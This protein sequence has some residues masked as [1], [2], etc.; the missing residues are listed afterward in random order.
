M[1]LPT[2][3]LVKT[4]VAVTSGFSGRIIPQGTEGTVVEQYAN[5]EGYAVDLALPDASLVGGY[6]YENVVLE[7]F[8]FEVVDIPASDDEAQ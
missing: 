8:Q 2:Y 4:L 1:P 5:P 7:P 6:D 3:T